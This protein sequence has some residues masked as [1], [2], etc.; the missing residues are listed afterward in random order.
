[1]GSAKKTHWL[2]AICRQTFWRVSLQETAASTV[3]PGALFPVG[4]DKTHW[5]FTAV[6]R[7][8]GGYLC[9]KPR[10]RRYPPGA[11]F[12]HFQ[13]KSVHKNLVG[14]KTHGCKGSPPKRTCFH[15]FSPEKRITAVGLRFFMFFLA[16]KYPTSGKTTEMLYPLPAELWEY[17]SR[18]RFQIKKKKAL[19]IKGVQLDLGFLDL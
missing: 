5:L 1:M 10:P 13:T 7:L 11:L 18:R 14:R 19:E 15:A 4:S 16:K 8:S 12:S 6:D 9:K 3:F 17:N 2:S